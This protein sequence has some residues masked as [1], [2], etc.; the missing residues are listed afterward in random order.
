MKVC[1]LC[2]QARP[3]DRFAADRRN[4][5]GL[6]GRCRDCANRRLRERRQ[7]E[8]TLAERDR[9]RN[10]AY[11]QTAAGLAT[12]RREYAKSRDAT[13]ARVAAW[14][15]KNRARA[16]A[17]KARAAHRR[18]ALIRGSA[19]AACAAQQVADRVAF[20]GDRC[21]ICR[22]EWEQIDH[23]KPLAKGGAHIPAN[24]RPICARCNRR[25]SARWPF[26]PR[27]G[28]AA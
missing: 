20:Y 21:W 1:N 7:E 5:D 27:E 6:Q 23:V 15:R 17:N 3:L 10:R 13:L 22:G 24:L 11:R 12:R 18:R 19:V 2:R 9:A 16:N 14:Q 8:P 26:T 4:S 25:K 28:I